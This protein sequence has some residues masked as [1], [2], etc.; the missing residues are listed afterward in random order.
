MLTGANL[1]WVP[2][3]DGE[4]PPTAVIG[5]TTEEGESLYIGRA[6]HEDTNTIGKVLTHSIHS[7]NKYFLWIFEKQCAVRRYFSKER[8]IFDY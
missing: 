2:A 7:S 4:V 5:G 6:K 8:R 3:Q 1:Q